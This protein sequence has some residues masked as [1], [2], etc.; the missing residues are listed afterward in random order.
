M[1]ARTQVHGSID[2]PCTV[3]ETLYVVYDG[4]AKP[5]VV[6]SVNIFIN[7]PGRVSF[8]MLLRSEQVGPLWNLSFSEGDFGREVFYTEE[9]AASA[10]KRRKK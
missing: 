1:K 8:L 3:G 7:K 6:D 2:L 4:Q 10:A 5:A 9:E